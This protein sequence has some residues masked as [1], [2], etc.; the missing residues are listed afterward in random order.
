MKNIKNFEE[1]I[2]IVKFS[3]L[4][5]NKNWSTEYLMNKEKGLTPYIKQG[6]LYIPIEPK[7]SIPKNAV[8]LTPEK[9]KEYNKLADQIK[10]LLNQQEN[11]ISK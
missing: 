5:K 6:G 9:V 2:N 8:Y 11:I 4:L 10:Q 7:K 1:Q 3:D